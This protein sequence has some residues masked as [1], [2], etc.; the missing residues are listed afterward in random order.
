MN[1][2]TPTMTA[3]SKT[4]TGREVSRKKSTYPM[5][6][7]INRIDQAFALGRIAPPRS[8]SDR[9]EP[10]VGWANSQR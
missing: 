1:V 10:N 6:P 5:N 4:F 2:D 9:S 8:Q 7:F 3:S